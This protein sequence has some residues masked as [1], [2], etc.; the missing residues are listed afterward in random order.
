MVQNPTK[1]NKKL[2]EGGN[3]DCGDSL[4][5]LGP[6]VSLLGLDLPLDDPADSDSD[7]D[8]A[9][10]FYHVPKVIPNLHGGHLQRDCQPLLRQ[11]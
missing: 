4:S 3:G 5:G 6:D 7:D 10:V 11:T 8:N 2:I 1:R 9:D